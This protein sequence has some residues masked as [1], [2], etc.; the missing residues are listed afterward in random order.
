MG[1]VCAACAAVARATVQAFFGS[2]PSKIWLFASHKAP[3]TGLPV[4][5]V[6]NPRAGFRHV[7]Q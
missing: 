1:D 5:I 7:T 6:R 4:V 3:L 2:E